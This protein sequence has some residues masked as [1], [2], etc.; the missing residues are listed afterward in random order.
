MVA[1]LQRVQ[2]GYAV[3]LTAEMVE[4]LHLTE[5]SAVEVLPVAAP[6]AEPQTQVRYATTE[7]ALR[8]F[9]ETLPQH[10][11]AYRELAK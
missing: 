5:G 4:A 6:T 9:E 7:D 10:E 8:A 11:A 1:R 3:V 2:N